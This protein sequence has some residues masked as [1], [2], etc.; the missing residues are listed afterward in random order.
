METQDNDENKDDSLR[1]SLTPT[2]LVSPTEQQQQR[3]LQMLMLKQ[4]Q[5]KQFQAA[6]TVPAWAAQAQLVSRP[7]RPIPQIPPDYLAHLMQPHLW[8]QLYSPLP[9]FKV[10]Q[11]PQLPLHPRPLSPAS[12]R[13]PSPPASRRAPTTTSRRQTRDE[14]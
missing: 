11:L 1:M 12:P 13:P 2:D 7:I 14:E 8:S 10:P 9:T 4:F 5:L 3:D 6:H